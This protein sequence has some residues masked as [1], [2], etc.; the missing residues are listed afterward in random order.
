MISLST[1]IYGDL[2]SVRQS[3]IRLM[4][5]WEYWGVCKKS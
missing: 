5:F 4:N 2:Q 1:V 3:G